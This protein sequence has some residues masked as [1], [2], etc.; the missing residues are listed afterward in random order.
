MKRRAIC[1]VWADPASL[2]LS[3][4][5]CLCRDERGPL[6]ASAPNLTLATHYSCFLS[7]SRDRLNA[8]G[9]GESCVSGHTF[10]VRALFETRVATLFSS[11]RDLWVD[12]D[13]SLVLKTSY[14][15]THEHAWPKMNMVHM[16]IAIQSVNNVGP[17]IQKKRKAGE[18]PG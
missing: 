1:T 8:A 6:I 15:N 18:L 10:A 3:C 17:R 16:W 7:A 2:A 11:K 4:A 9:G 14:N 13:E 5:S 12:F